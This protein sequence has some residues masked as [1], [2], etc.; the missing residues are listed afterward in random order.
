VWL[1]KLHHNIALMRAIDI[2]Q[3]SFPAS[4]TMATGR[5]TALF[6]ARIH[7]RGGQ[8]VVSSAEMLSV[9][10]FLEGRHARP[11]PASG[12]SPAIAKQRLSL[13]P[14]GNI[15]YQLK[16]PYGDGTT[17]VI[18]EPL[19]S[20]YRKYGMPRAQGC[21]G[22][23]IARLAALVP[24]PRVNLTSLHGGGLSPTASTARG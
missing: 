21:A 16:T 8:G 22:A 12:R 10:A 4:W 14:N 15:R 3:Q 9:A 7:G 6:Q 5:R 18:F 13:T 11:F 2:R 17:H 20:M 19:D 23:A 24:K 1:Q